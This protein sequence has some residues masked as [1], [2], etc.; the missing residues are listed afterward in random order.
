VPL[1]VAAGDVLDVVRAAAGELAEE[2]RLFDVY[3][4]ENLPEGTK[5]LAFALRLRGERTLTGEDTAAVRD[6]VV[7]AA[8]ERFGAALR[9]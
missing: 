8:G 1:D 5:S 2:V 4:G 7:S 6:A 9:S 3:T